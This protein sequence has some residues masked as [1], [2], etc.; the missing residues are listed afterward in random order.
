MPGFLECLAGIADLEFVA[1]VHMV[2]WFSLLELYSLGQEQRRH[3]ADLIRIKIWLD[4]CGV[5]RKV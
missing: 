4:G 1:A 5:K 2:V 3:P